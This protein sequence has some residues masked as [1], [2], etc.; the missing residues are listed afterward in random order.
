MTRISLG[1][2]PAP[3]GLQVLLFQGRVGCY[4]R[5]GAMTVSRGT[6]QF[7][8]ISWGCWIFATVSYL[9]FALVDWLLNWMRRR[10]PF[11]GIP[12]FQQKLHPSENQLLK[13]IL[14]GIL[15]LEF[16]SLLIIFPSHWWF[17]TFFIFPYI[18][19]NHP[20][21]LSYFSDM[22]KPPTSSRNNHPNWLIFFR[23]VAQPPTSYVLIIFPF[24][25]PIFSSPVTATGGKEGRGFPLSWDMLET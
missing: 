4:E 16:F 15:M 19:N 12:L 3:W 25:S 7:Q 17:G 21:W 18:G 20:N 23:G 24:E 11:S 22:L 1:G 8:S 13:H 14:L 9:H 10:G 6:C 2:C 5:R